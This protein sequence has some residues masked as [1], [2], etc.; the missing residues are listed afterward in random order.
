MK[1][2]GEKPKARFIK[3]T[4]LCGVPLKRLY[5]VAKTSVVLFEKRLCEI[6]C[7]DCQ[8]FNI[9]KLHPVL[10]LLTPPI[11]PKMVRTTQIIE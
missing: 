4:S 9:N 8:H 11:K 7:C 5:I 6:Q 2:D 3:H 1:R 10:P